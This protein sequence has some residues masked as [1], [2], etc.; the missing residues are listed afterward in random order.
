MVR[1]SSLWVFLSS[2]FFLFRSALLLSASPFWSL[3]AAD[4]HRIGVLTRQELPLS[5]GGL[6][7]H[8]LDVQLESVLLIGC[9]LNGLACAAT[10]EPCCT[11]SKSCDGAGN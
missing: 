6:S 4:R 9:V 7:R 11:G 1:V 5:P 3:Q 2:G 10:S 8:D